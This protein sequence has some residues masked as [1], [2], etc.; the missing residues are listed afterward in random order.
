[1]IITHAHALTSRTRRIYS[2]YFERDDRLL[3][4][5]YQYL[6]FWLCCPRAWNSTNLL[7]HHAVPILF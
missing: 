7:Y 5:L 4:R 6:Q 3:R 2:I 1:M